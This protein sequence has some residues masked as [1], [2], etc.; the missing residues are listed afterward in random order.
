MDNKKY[1]MDLAERWFD[2]E[3]TEA[4]ELELKRFLAGTDDPD[5]DEAKAALGYLAAEGALSNSQEITKKSVRLWPVLAVAAS[6]AVAFVLGRLLRW[7]SGIPVRMFL[8]SM[9]WWFL[10]RNS[11]SA[12]WNRRLRACLLLPPIPP[13][14]SP[15]C[16]ADNTIMP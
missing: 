15:S 6:V 3:T 2:A 14:T 13:P 12:K 8:M 9:A 11:P 10:Q 4:E 7:S 1:Y 5:F 16:S